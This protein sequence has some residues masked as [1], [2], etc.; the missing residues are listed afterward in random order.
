MDWPLA[1][2]LAM[3]AQDKVGVAVIGA[4]FICDYHVAGIRAAGTGD[5]TT[6]VGRN[7]DRTVG[8][9]PGP[10]VTSTS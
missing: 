10:L 4:G 1:R 2:I 6:L 9:P 7:R 8:E 5:I 3:S